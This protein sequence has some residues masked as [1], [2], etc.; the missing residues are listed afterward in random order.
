MT[1]KQTPK[2]PLGN[3]WALLTGY[4]V[5]LPWVDVQQLSGPPEYALGVVQVRFSGIAIAT[6]KVLTA[7]QT[8]LDKP[9]AMVELP[10]RREEWLCLY[11]GE[12]QSISLAR[13]ENCGAPRTWLL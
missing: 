9:S 12:P 1:V 7:M 4:K 5:D 2:K 3:Q 6:T 10:V 13:C 8:W 11:C